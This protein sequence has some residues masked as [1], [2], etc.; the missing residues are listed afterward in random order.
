M[1]R[2]LF[3][4]VN[5]SKA[6]DSASH[7]YVSAFFRKM[8]PTSSHTRMLLFLFQAPVHLILP[9]GI[10]HG[11]DIRPQSGP[12]HGCLLS[13]VL[14]SLLISPII[15]QLR[16]STSRVRVL[17]Y[18]DDVMLIFNCCP[19]QAIEQLHR[20]LPDFEQFAHYT[21]LAKL[22]LIPK[23]EWTPEHKL[24]LTRTCMQVIACAK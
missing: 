16:A 14:L 22:Y 8:G 7:V 11:H 10:C 20:C 4:P 2:G 3:V 23:G 18:A 24:L 5:F 19:H 12:R 9:A 17:V 13:P 15:Q 1:E 6:F 21:G